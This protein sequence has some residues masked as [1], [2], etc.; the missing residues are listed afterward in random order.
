MAKKITQY[1]RVLNTD[2]QKL[3]KMSQAELAEEVSIVF[4]AA[5][6][7]IRRLEKAGFSDDT[8]TP[9]LRYTMKHGGMFS[10]EGMNQEQLLNELKRAKGF[11]NAKTSTVT[12]AKKSIEKM[13]KILSKM[14]S[15]KTGTPVKYEMTKEEVAEYWKAVD[16]LRELRPSTFN[17]KCLEYVGRIEDYIERGRTGRQAA[18]YINRIMEKA[19]KEVVKKADEIDKE[20]SKY[21]EN[22]LGNNNL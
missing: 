14:E 11:M 19:T 22:E 10:A 17:D 2:V 8:A 4:R 3:E 16:R 13:N 18:S 5:N 6:R 1:Q 9:A 7:R 15:E 21:G 12:G 20:M